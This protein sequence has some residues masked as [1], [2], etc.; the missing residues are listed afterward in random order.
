M[1]RTLGEARELIIAASPSWL[2]SHHAETRRP[3][4]SWTGD[5]S[6]SPIGTFCPCWVTGFFFFLFFRVFFSR[7]TMK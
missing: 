7:Q 5:G 6:V 3:G 4:P 2:S 1:R